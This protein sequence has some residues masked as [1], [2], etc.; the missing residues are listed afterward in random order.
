MR[1][2]ILCL[3]LLFSSPA[4][5]QVVIPGT[6]GGTVVTP[7][8]A[9]TQ[10]VPGSCAGTDKVTG[11]TATGSLVC[12]TDLTGSTSPLTTKGD[13]FGFS[14][15][16]DRLPVGANDLC[17]IADS[18]QALGLRWGSCGAGGGD[19]IT[20]NTVAA[21]D[22]DFIDT[23]TI[24]VTLNTVPTPDTIE[25]AVVANSIN[26]THIDETAN[27]TWT[28]QHSLVG[29]E[30]LGASPIRFEGATDDNIYTILAF[31]DPTSSS[32]TI[33]FPNATGGVPLT[34]T[35]NTFTNINQFQSSVIMTDGVGDSPFFRIQ[36][37]TGTVFDIIA[38]D[39]DDDLRVTADTASTEA[40][41]FEN[42]GVGV[43][44]VFIETSNGV[45]TSL[46]DAAHLT[47]GTL[48]DARVDGSL[49]AD[50]L[51]LAGDV[52][53]TANA[54]DL[55]EAAVEVELEGV[56]D[57][58]D[59]Q[60]I[61]TAAKGGTGDDTSVTTG[62][63]R[64]AAG[65]WTYDAGISHLAASTS[66]DLRGVLSDEVGTGA[67]MFGLISTMNDD[68]ACTGSQV[69]RRNA[70]DTAFECATISAG[71]APT[72]ATYL[73]Q[74]AH[75]SLTAEQVAVGGA[76]IAITFAGGDG[77]NATFATASSEADFL[78]SGAL[79]CGA[80]TQGK[81]Q[82]HT[83]PLQYCDNAATPAL[84]YAAYGASDGDA[85]AGDSATDFFDAGEIERARLP[86]AIA[87]EDEANAFTSLQT[88]AQITQ[89]GDA[90]DGFFLNLRN[91]AVIAWEDSPAGGDTTL[92]VNSLEELSTSASVFNLQNN[93]R[94]TLTHTGLTFEGATDNGFETTI[95]ITD[96]T[97]DRTVFVA[98]ADT[99]TGQDVTCGGT[100]K[101]S[102]FSA[103]TGAFTCS[104]DVSGGSPT[105][106][107]IANPAG[108]QA[109]TMGANNTTWT[110]DSASGVY[111]S[112]HSSAF[113][114]GTQFRVDASGAFTGGILVGIDQHTGNP[115]AGT[116][117][118]LRA[119]D[120]NVTVLRAG[121]GTNGIT[122]SQAGALTAE[123]TGSITAT[124]LTCTGCVATAEIGDDQVTF[125][126]MQNITTDRLLG[127]DTAASGDTEEISLNATLEFTGS[128]SIQRAALTGDVTASAGS[129]TTTIASGVVTPAKLSAAAREEIHS[130]DI[131]T[132]TTADTNLVQHKFPNAVTILR[133][134]CSTD[135]G[136]ATIQFDERAEATPNTA[137]TNVLT[138]ALVCDTTSEATTSFSNAGIAADAPLNLQITATAS[139][140]GVVRLH[141]EFQAD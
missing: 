67:A 73:V 55:D 46:K 141:I 3:A 106:D 6:G 137:G 27:Y 70:G 74:T 38:A 102:A 64:I 7:A 81:A 21:T 50:E 10:V 126:K 23:G 109:L 4:W 105:W 138:A 111:R 77:G 129:N 100:D 123:G 17:L 65:N 88:F 85:L 71:G 15:V 49:E 108:A 127:R 97:A 16:D 25:W 95:S 41:E 99:A 22:P 14:T 24:D 26:A 131:F 20:V 107:S 132:P 44:D 91:S 68:L 125:A 112:T 79:T 39:S 75:A 61:L 62:V 122:L 110:W 98:D 32:K 135:V 121:D 57:L 90:A 1:K 120:V 18:T 124:E 101:V 48:A 59:L 136:T 34:T 53:G 116:L 43:M 103:A 36:P 76:G 58:P 104:A 52:N 31:T 2:L 42:I 84:Q 37:Q 40:V 66:A 47:T 63:P 69:V 28:G 119:A 87:Y 54:N 83:T 45:L 94:T 80:S 118:D 11:V 13:I 72:D 30:L 93:F 12:N 51:V 9:K 113:S 33:T 128:A 8:G 92:F 60:G 134:S 86:A 139:T 29:A 130:I 56:L 82:V 78:A 133:V 89:D 117:V 115:T 35:S 96:P 114:T 19:S 140:P 5:A